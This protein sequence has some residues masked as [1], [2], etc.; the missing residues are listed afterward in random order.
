V[1]N[2]FDPTSSDAALPPVG[3]VSERRQVYRSNDALVGDV[4][5]YERSGYAMGPDG[6]IY[7]LQ[8]VASTQALACG[9]HPRSIEDLGVCLETSLLIC[10][11]L[12]GANCC[13]CGGF[14]SSPYLNVRRSGIDERRL[15]ICWRCTDVIDTPIWKQ[16]LRWLWGSFR[17]G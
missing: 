15:L 10:R 13:V 7:S 1:T 2:P 8:E 3:V 11:T 16:W 14:Y 6:V 9:C 12:H 17:R 5:L 4:N